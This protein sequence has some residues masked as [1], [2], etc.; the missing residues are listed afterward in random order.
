MSACH[1]RMSRVIVWR[2]SS[3]G[4]SSPSWMSSTSLVDAEHL[5]RGRRLRRAPLGERAAGHLP[6]ADVAV[7]HGD[8][9]HV[10]AQ[11]RPLGRRAAGFVFGIV[12]MGAED[13]D[14]QLAVLRGVGTRTL[15]GSDPGNAEQDEREEKRSQESAMAVASREQTRHGVDND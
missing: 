8:E 9:L 7:G 6:V 15:C 3:V 4:T 14:P 1:S 11:L 2:F 10:M 12:G 5:G 13:D